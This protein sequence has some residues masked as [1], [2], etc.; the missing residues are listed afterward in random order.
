MLWSANLQ[1]RAVFAMCS[2]KVSWSSKIITVWSLTSS[3]LYFIL[4]YISF[5][6]YSTYIYA[7]IFLVFRASNIAFFES[8]G[9]FLCFRVKC[10]GHVVQSRSFQ[11]AHSSQVEM[12]SSTRTWTLFTSRYFMAIWRERTFTLLPSVLSDMSLKSLMGGHV[13]WGDLY[14]GQF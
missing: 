8:A 2:L 9:L 4:L 11:K 10:S 1:D 13:L 12:T 3:F 14:Q 7:Y 5:F 6:H